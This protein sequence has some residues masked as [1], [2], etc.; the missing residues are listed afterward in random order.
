MLMLKVCGKHGPYMRSQAHNTERGERVKGGRAHKGSSEKLKRKMSTK[1]DRQGMAKK[2]PPGRN[3]KKEN[4]FPLTDSRL[5][6][7]YI[8]RIIPREIL[9]MIFS[10]HSALYGSISFFSLPLGRT[11]NL[12]NFV[13]CP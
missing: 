12:F 6:A 5:L 3:G 7:V 11:N 1:I 4:I 9:R 2:Q 13:Y 8:P 10:S